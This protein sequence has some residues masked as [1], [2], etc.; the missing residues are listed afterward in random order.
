MCMQVSLIFCKILHDWLHANN[1]MNV[2]CDHASKHGCILQYITIYIICSIY[3]LT[4]LQMIDVYMYMYTWWHCTYNNGGKVPKR[5]SK[6][7]FYL[8]QL[9]GFKQVSSCQ[10][11]VDDHHKREEDEPTIWYLQEEGHIFQHME[12]FLFIQFTSWFII[13]DCID[14]YGCRDD[15]HQS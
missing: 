14:A 12:T 7:D 8:H 15:T 5:I 6:M 2:Q 1:T 13:F 11:L 4:Q 9:D 3:I 10:Y